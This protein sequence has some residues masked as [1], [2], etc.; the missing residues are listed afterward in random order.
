[1]K[2]HLVKRITVE[3]YAGKHS[4]GKKHFDSFLASIEDG[5]WTTPQ[6]MLLSYSGNLLNSKR[7]VFDVGGNGSNS[8]RI[9]CEF[10]FGRKQVH[11]YVCW[12]GTHEAYNHLTEEQ[13]ITINTY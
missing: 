3:K 12:I 6:D 9:I 10:M 1:M 13:K 4:N 11:L 8:F 7:V 5:E 2:V